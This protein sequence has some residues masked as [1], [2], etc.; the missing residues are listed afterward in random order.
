M[1]EDGPCRHVSTSLER[2][3]VPRCDSSRSNLHRACLTSTDTTKF[4]GNIWVIDLASGRATKLAEHGAP[5]QD[6]VPAW[7]P[8]G[9]RIAFQSNRTGRWERRAPVRITEPAGVHA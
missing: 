3:S 2:L 5:Y 1:D 4:I 8:D 6:E 9:K 7:F